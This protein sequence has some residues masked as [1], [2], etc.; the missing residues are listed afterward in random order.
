MYPQIII[1]NPYVKE[2]TLIHT[3]LIT[4]KYLTSNH[5]TQKIA[6]LQKYW[7]MMRAVCHL[8]ATGFLFLL[9]FSLFFFPACVFVVVVIVVVFLCVLLI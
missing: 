5:F 7:K 9:L 2:I 6:M 1:Q 4:E 3:P 8:L